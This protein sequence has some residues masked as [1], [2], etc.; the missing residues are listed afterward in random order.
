MY[1]S[2][3]YNCSHFVSNRL[4]STCSLLPWQ[5][6]TSSTVNNRRVKLHSIYKA[7]HK[8]LLNTFVENEKYLESNLYI[9]LKLS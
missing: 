7:L 3:K 6:Y 9:S 5:L 1:N 4:C 8:L 2:C